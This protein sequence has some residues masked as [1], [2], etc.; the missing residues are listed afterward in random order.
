VAAGDKVGPDVNG[1]TV[2]G[3]TLGT[4]LE[5]GATGSIVPVLVD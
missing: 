3:G 5:T 2:T 4:A 1:A